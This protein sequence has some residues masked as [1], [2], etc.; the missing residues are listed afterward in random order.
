MKN[1][2]TKN[3]MSVDGA[4]STPLGVVNVVNIMKVISARDVVCLE[5]KE[6]VYDR[7]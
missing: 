4:K 7:S 6:N 2:L 1:L 5:K 3:M